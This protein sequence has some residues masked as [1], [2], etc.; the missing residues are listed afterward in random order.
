MK[1]QIH[2]TD[3]VFKAIVGV[4]DA[5]REETQRVVV[6]ADIEYEYKGE[7]LHHVD[8]AALIKK[9]IVTHKYKVLEDALIDITKALQQKYSNITNIH[10]KITKPDYQAEYVFSASVSV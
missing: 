8:V 5:E 3:F 2:I 9:Q 4:F 6:N 7:Y 1:M 10:M